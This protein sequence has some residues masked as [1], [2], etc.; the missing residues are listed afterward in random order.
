MPETRLI[1][2]ADDFG[3]S[4][5]ITDGIVLA[6]RYGFV[7][8]ASL[9]VNMSASKYA[10]ARAADFPALGVGIHLNIC[11]GRPILS[12]REI[13][14]LVGAN[15]EFHRPHILI[16]KLWR[17]QV[18]AREIEAEFRAQ[19]QWMKHRGLTPTHADSHHHMH[20]YPSAVAPFVRAL[21][22]ETITCTRA[23]RLAVFPRAHS[24]GG[25]YEGPV[26]RRCAAQLYR[27]ILHSAG[28][29][30]FTMPDGRISFLSKH[31]HDFAMLRERWTAALRSLP[32]GTFELACHP[33]LFERGFSETDA[34]RLQREEELSWLTDREL[35]E[36][37]DRNQV[38]LIDYRNLVPSMSPIPIAAGEAQTIS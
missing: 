9:L 18:S 8:S 22:A 15:G 36:V 11:S 33:G 38:A 21:R 29:R 20:I 25:P 10:L 4:R 16:R 2:N 13:P 37:L 23:S 35:L 24:L 32:G 5:G 28:F 1:V 31:R 7:T 12:P 14:T 30:G 19:I 6:H 34:I 17:W 3:M 26:A 27:S